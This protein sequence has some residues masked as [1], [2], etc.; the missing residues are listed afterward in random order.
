MAALA[1]RLFGSGGV[2]LAAGLAAA[3][4]P[5]LV[6][7]S[8]DI[9]SETIFVPLLLGAG[10]FLLHAADRPSTSFAL[11]AGVLLAAAALTRPSA[12]A[13]SP[14]LAA[15]LF[16]RRWPLR[17]RAHLAGAALLGFLLALGPWTAR[18]ALRYHEVIPVSDSAG[19]TFYDGNSRFTLG[20]YG[21]RSRAEL[22]ERVAEMDARKAAHIASLPPDARRSPSRRSDALIALAVEELRAD[23]AGARRLYGRKVLEWFRPYPSPLFWP[24]PAV[25]AVGLV[26]VA[27]FGLGGLGLYRAHRRGAA[28]FTLVFLVA[29]M[30]VHVAFL[31]VWRFRTPYWNPALLLYG[32]SLAGDRLDRW[33]PR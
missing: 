28:L 19:S 6:M 32:A 16:D 3:L 22:E 30:A 26:N 23:P 18:N 33:K 7:L 14:L 27:L 11:A 13:L 24:W 5:S 8:A 9:Q 10:L 17:A 12:L 21:A 25:A 20:L 15:P 29:A 2:A 4:D 31:A 1:L